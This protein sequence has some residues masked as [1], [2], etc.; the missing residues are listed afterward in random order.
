MRYGQQLSV[1]VIIGLFATLIITIYLMIP[2]VGMIIDIFQNGNAGDSFTL[3]H[4]SLIGVT[5]LATILG[6]FIIWFVEQSVGY[7]TTDTSHMLLKFSGKLFL[8]SALMIA[9]FLLLS[10]L[11]PSVTEA[12]EAFAV[13]VKYVLAITFIGGAAAFIF[14]CIQGLIYMWKL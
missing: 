10:P 14:A 8:Y 7:K 4:S 1:W 5:L 6:G 11:I 9:I 3:L 12:S 13:S 2:I